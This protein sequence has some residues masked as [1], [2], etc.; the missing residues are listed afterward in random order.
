[1]RVTAASTAALAANAVNS[2]GAANIVGQFKRRFAKAPIA[3]TT[4]RGMMI[5][6]AFARR[7]GG[8]VEED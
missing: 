8:L 1:M 6:P 4:A 3:A 5:K 7:C 2:K